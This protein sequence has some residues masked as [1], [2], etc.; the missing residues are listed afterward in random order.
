M[1]ILNFI[2]GIYLCIL[3][4]QGNCI[5]CI[6]HLMKMKLIL[7]YK[8]IIVKLLYILNQKYVNSLI[9]ISLFSLIQNNCISL[10]FEQP[11]MKMKLLD[12]LALY[13]ICFPM[14]LTIVIKIRKKI[15]CRKKKNQKKCIKKMDME[16]FF[17]LLIEVD[18]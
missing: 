14:H 9:M 6:H 5:I 12:N 1:I 16:N 18:Q 15:S 8:K 3:K 7:N 13:Q 2:R 17:L 10:L 4:C 11:N